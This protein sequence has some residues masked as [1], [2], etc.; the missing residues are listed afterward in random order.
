MTKVSVIGAGNVGATCAA[1]SYTHL[2]VYKRQPVTVTGQYA[3]S[4]QLLVRGRALN[5]AQGMEVLVPFRVDGGAILLVDRGWVPNGD[6]AA[7][8]PT[9][10]PCLLYTSRCV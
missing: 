8:L 4:G 5:T 1:V 9:V 6:Q 7:D 3:A 10:P 2:D